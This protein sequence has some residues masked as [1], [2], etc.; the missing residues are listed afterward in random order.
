MLKPAASSLLC[1]IAPC[2]RRAL[3]ST[4]PWPHQPRRFHTQSPLLAPSGF[5]NMPPTKP[6]KSGKAS[7]AAKAILHPKSTLA[8]V[9]ANHSRGSSIDEDRTQQSPA[10]SVRKTPSNASIASSSNKPSSRPA[11]VNASPAAA[12][13]NL[14]TAAAPAPSVLAPPIG[15]DILS[16]K[17]QAI[18]R[19]DPVQQPVTAAASTAPAAAAPSAPVA[20]TPAAPAASSGAAHPLDVPYT[21]DEVPNTKAMPARPPRKMDSQLCHRT[22][23]LPSPRNLRLRTSSPRMLPPSSPAPILLRTKNRQQPLSLPPL[24]SP[25]PLSPRVPTQPARPC[26]P[27]AMRHPS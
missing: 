1:Q 17:K 16:M 27:R 10:S 5:V 15:T 20:S 3:L 8:A 14:P 22:E 19:A 18:A 2:S 25:F 7:K 4:S 24:R 26:R 6:S 9:K 11:S 13:A 23:Q 21:I 12:T